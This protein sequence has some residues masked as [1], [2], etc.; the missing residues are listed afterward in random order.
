VVDPE[1]V[2]VVVDIET[3]GRRSAS[4]RITEVAA[5]KLQHGEVIDRWQSLINPCR[6]I[7]RNITDLTGI[8]NEMAADAPVFA[9]I[10]EDFRAFT[11]GAVFV[12]HNVRFDYSFIGDEYRRLQQTYQRPTLC[13]CAQMRKWYPGFKSYSLKNLCERFEISLESHHRAMCDAEAAAELLALIN[14]KRT[15]QN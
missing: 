12:A 10:A 14:Q 11:E 2:Y 8:S 9:E 4:N 1:Q 3:T 15:A 5:V 7:P 13:S 6:S